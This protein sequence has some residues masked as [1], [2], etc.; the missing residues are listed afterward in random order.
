MF[1]IHLSNPFSSHNFSKEEQER[2]DVWKLTREFID[3]V[4]SDESLID[5]SQNNIHYTEYK[6]DN[7]YKGKIPATD[8]PNPSIELVNNDPL[9]EAKL[10]VKQGYKTLVMNPGRTQAPGGGVKSGEDNIEADIYRRTTLSAHINNIC[11]H[12]YYPMARKSAVLTKDVLV[13]RDMAPDYEFL[14]DNYYID[15]L[16]IAPSDRP[17]IT[18][19][20]YSHKYQYPYEEKTMEIKIELFFEIAFLNSYKA[21]VITDIGCRDK[22]YPHPVEEVARIIKRMAHKYRYYF[23]KIIVAVMSDV[24][25]FDDPTSL[26]FDIF[27]LIWDETDE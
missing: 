7:I 8:S 13:F 20:H 21:V 24:D 18:K 14:E 1:N 5:L 19:T 26:N 17:V 11:Y 12:S 16:T 22:N 6:I 4:Y 25:D 9:K 2:I 3:E 23:D 27:S 15:V 10:L